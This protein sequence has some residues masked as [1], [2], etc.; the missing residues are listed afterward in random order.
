MPVLLPVLKTVLELHLCDSFKLFQL[1]TF[2]LGY[3]C[4]KIALRGSFYFSEQ[5]NDTCGYI[6]Q[7]WELG[8]HYSVVF[9]PKIHEQ[10][11][12]CEREH[13]CDAIVMNCFATNQGV[14][15]GLLHTNGVELAGGK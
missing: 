12:M 13:Y 2:N 8:H 5:K 14:F 10:A 11:T 1:C 15:F 4:K 3:A 7:I 6:E 9:L